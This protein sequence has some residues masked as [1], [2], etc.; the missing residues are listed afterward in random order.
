MEE[1]EAEGYRI[2]YRVGL[3]WLQTYRTTLDQVR[4]FYINSCAREVRY[5]LKLEPTRCIRVGAIDEPTI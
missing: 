4:R 3:R 2:Q 5:S 1:R